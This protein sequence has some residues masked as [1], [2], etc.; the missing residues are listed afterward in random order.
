MQH[1]RAHVAQFAQ[2]V[3][4]DALDGVGVFDYARVC[5]E[6][7]GNIRPVFVDVRSERR[8]GKRTRYV[9]AAAGENA[10]AAVGHCAV[11][12]GGDDFSACGEAL[13]L[14]IGALGVD[15]AVKGKLQPQL[16]VEKIIAEEVRHQKRREIFSARDELVLGYAAFDLAAQRREPCVNVNAELKLRAYLAVT[17]RYHLKHRIAAHAVFLVRMAQI[18][19]IGELVVV[20]KSLA[21]RGHDDDA[22][23]GVRVD[24]RFNFSELARVRHGRAAEFCYLKHITSV[25]R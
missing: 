1:L 11:K 10:D 6:Y 14:R 17:L 18:Q 16:R 20:L 19:K 7:A 8:R 22:P 12:A 24:D 5:H 25:P 9:A 13:K 23:R 21:R 4:G 2:L 15:A 3:I